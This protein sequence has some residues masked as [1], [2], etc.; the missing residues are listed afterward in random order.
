MR[1]ATCAS[2]NTL[3][4]AQ[5][6]RAARK[7]LQAQLAASGGPGVGA[8][9]PCPRGLRAKRTAR[10]ERATSAHTGGGYV[11]QHK[12]KGG[13]VRQ[14]RNTLRGAQHA[15]AARKSLQAQLAAGRGPGVGARS[16]SPRGLR[17][18]RA[19][20]RE[21]ATSAPCDRQL[22]APVHTKH[23]HPLPCAREKQRAAPSQPSTWEEDVAATNRPHTQKRRSPLRVHLNG[24]R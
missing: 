8:R 6:A 15:R 14:H 1:V 3:R 23:R 2:T 13:R 20:R 24:L 11:R 9:S 12:H 19:A 5:H 4:G 10:R 16:P 7:S 17:A 18:A 21:R 22:H